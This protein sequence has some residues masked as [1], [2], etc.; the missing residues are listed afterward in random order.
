MKAFIRVGIIGAVLLSIY[1]ILSVSA[2]WRVKKSFPEG[3][4]EQ[5]AVIRKLDR[6][7]QTLNKL[8]EKYFTTTFYKRL[9]LHHG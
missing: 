5:K 8:G 2:S 4:T 6:I 1:I 3:A 9:Y 7:E